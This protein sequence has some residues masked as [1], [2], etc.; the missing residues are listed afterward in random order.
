MDVQQNNRRD[1]ASLMERVL[2]EVKKVIVGQDQ[3]CMLAVWIV[4][5]SETHTRSPM[6]IVAGCRRCKCY[7][8]D[9][10]NRSKLAC[11]QQSL[12]STGNT[13]INYIV[14]IETE[15]FTSEIIDLLR[16]QYYG[17]KKPR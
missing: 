9:L 11:E 6:I 1:V 7:V 13:D 17:N 4:S 3:R 15:A 12:F 5:I 16:D 14:L 10:G 8:L 2:Y